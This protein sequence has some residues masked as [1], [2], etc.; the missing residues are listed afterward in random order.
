MEYRNILLEVTDYTAVITLNRPDKL[1]AL[2]IELLKELY[3]AFIDL[4]N[5]KDVHAVIITAAEKKLL[6]Q[7]P[8]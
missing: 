8:I 4:S 3:S 7:V 2:N 1:N 6:L 5:N